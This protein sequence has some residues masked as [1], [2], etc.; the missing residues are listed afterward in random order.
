MKILFYFGGF[1]PIGG[2]ETFCKNLLCYLQSRNYDCQLVCWG[3]NS[4]L[5]QS[6]EQA[7]VKIV[8]NPWQWGCRWNLPD[9][10]LLP[11]GIQQIKQSNIVLFGKLF[12]VEILKR[13]KSQIGKSTKFVYI[14]PY[15]PLPPTTTPEKNQ[16]LEALN[17]FDLILVQASAFTEDLHQIGYQGRV[18]V[19]SYIPQ[20]PS[21]LKPLPANEQLRIGFLGRLVEDKNIPLLLET[22]RCFQEK[23]LQTSIADNKQKQKPSLHLFGDG[24]LREQLEQLTQNL[25]IASSVVFHGSIPNNEV[26]N[27]I[28]SCHLFAF[29]SRTEGQCLAALEILGCG[30]PIV[31]TNVGALPDILSDARLGRIVKSTNANEFA[32]RLM[33][34]A[35]LIE[36]QSISPDTIRSAY[37]ERYA[38]ENLGDRYEKIFNSLSPM[39]S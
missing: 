6:I 10:L 33:E 30:R 3:P 39:N 22:F 23:Y 37:L 5:L 25:G 7:K 34:I 14:T 12:P 17:L 24:H 11:L 2:I 19:I 32:D 13:L 36:Q 26:E 1:A 20:Q 18:E 35:K 27:A 15:Q 38:P 29:T 8:R 28:A 4:S 9:W 31:A 21:N 16:L